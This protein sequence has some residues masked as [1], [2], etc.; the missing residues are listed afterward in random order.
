MAFNINDIRSQMALGGARPSF[1]QVHITNPINPIA[2]IKAP[3]MT[4]AATLPSWETSVV[5]VFYF[6]RQIKLSGT[7]T[8]EPWTVTVMNDEDFLVRN[9]IEQWSN[10][11]NSLE[12]N[13]QTTGTSAPSSY[14][15]QGTVTQFGKAGQVLRV[16][17]LNGIWPSNI[18]AIDLDW[19][20]GDA[21]EEFQITFQ[22]DDLELIGGQTGNAGGV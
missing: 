13:L 17:Q 14:K 7:R 21:I 2:D 9:T 3:F 22:F 19:A 10:A 6:G 18:T 20:T 8:F 15:S 12:G 4:K 16:Y 1:F 5:P 11:M